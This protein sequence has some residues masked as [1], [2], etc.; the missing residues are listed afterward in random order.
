M[1][2]IIPTPDTPEF[3]GAFTDRLFFKLDM[4]KV[5]PDDLDSLSDE[6]INYICETCANEFTSN[7]VIIETSSIRIAGGWTDNSYGWKAE[8]GKVSRENYAWQSTYE[9]RC[10]NKDL[11]W[12][13]MK[14]GDKNYPT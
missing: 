3:K 12:F 5:S 11:M 13:L 2:E 4:S 1:I 9:L 14:F 8:G 6:R 7:F 10:Y